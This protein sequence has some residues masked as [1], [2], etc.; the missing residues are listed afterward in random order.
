[1]I[2]RAKTQL[3]LLDG[4]LNRRRKRSRSD[5]LLKRIDEFI[6][7]ERLVEVCS[8]VF[9]DSKRGRPSLP[10]IFSLKSLFLQFLYDL[11][12]PALEDALTDRLSFQR[13]VG[14]GFEEDA[15]DFTTI[16]RFRERLVKAGLYD[17]LFELINEDLEARGVVLKRGTLVDATIVTSARRPR[18]KKAADEEKSARGRAQEDGDAR[19][20]Q[21]GGRIYYGYKGHIG[22]DEGSGVIRRKAFTAAEVH[23]SQKTDELISGDERSVFG[24]KAYMSAERKRGLRQKGVWCGILDKGYRNRPL[25]EKQKRLN[26]RKSRVRSAV[27]RPFAHFRRLYGYGRARYLNLKRNDLEFTFLCMIYNVRRGIALAAA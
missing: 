13:F 14:M 3:N 1:M 11:S 20:T 17:R 8:V 6:D 21:K 27:E 4:V 25:S 22:V 15:P 23:D 7:W 24:D 2:G 19:F 18:R 12:D 26:S 9:K 5:E 16:W 10:V